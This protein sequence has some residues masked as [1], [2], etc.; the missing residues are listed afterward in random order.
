[1]AACQWSLETSCKHVMAVQTSS[2]QKRTRPPN[3]VGTKISAVN[4][5]LHVSSGIPSLDNITG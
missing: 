4:S 2:F 5:T 3:I 1:M